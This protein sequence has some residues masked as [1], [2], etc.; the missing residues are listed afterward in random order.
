[1]KVLFIASGNSSQGISPIVRNQAESLQKAGVEVNLFPVTGK[2]FFG[3]LRNIFALKTHLS[4]NN[5]DIIHAHYGFSAIVALFA[6]KGEKLVV[7]FMGDDLIGSNR[8]NGKVRLT[9]KFVV[10]LNIVLSRYFYDYCIVKSNEMFNNLNI[11]HKALIPNGIDLKKFYHIRK[12]N[13]LI[14]IGLTKK[15]KIGIFVSNPTRPEKNFN[16]AREAISLINNVS[17]DLMTLSEIENSVLIYYYNA[18]DFLILTSYHEGSP[19]VIKEAMA[20]NCPIVATDVG[21]IRWVIGDTEGCYI[22]SFDPSDVA[23]KIKMALEF[24]E[25]VGRTKGRER[26]IKLGL[27]S[28][29]IAKR[30]ISVYEKVLQNY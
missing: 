17:V 7:S 14:K 29:T 30:I 20:C 5:Y 4:V 26:I 25:K 10:A 18:A 1:M 13:A 24:S 23:E 21:D 8:M 12:D 27:D 3:Y 11:K 22:T 16:L 19:N 15:N 2:G 9:S 28:E 6:R